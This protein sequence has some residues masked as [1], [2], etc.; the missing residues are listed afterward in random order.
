[1][2][3]GNIGMSGKVFIGIHLICCCIYKL[4]YLSTYIEKL[5]VVKIKSV[6]KC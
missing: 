6:A 2:D 3:G 4:K 5:V 1:M